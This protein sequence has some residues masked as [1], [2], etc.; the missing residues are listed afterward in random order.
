ML[1]KVAQEPTGPTTL[2]VEGTEVG[3][4]HPPVLVEDVLVDDVKMLE[5]AVELSEAELLEDD[6][7]I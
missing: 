3:R 6:A 1:L 2:A 7:V 4:I 5:V